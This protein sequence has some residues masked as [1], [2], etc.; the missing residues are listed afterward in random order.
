MSMATIARKSSAPAAVKGKFD[1][2][3]DV[4][5]IGSGVAGLATALFSRWHGNDVLVLEKANRLGGTTRKAAFWYWVPNNAA[6][7]AAGIKDPKKD[8]IA[9]MARLSRPEVYDPKAPKFGMPAWDYAQYEAIYDNASTATEL[10]SKKGALEYRHCDFVP[11]YWAEL[12]E[13]KAPK[14]RVLLPKGA[15]ESMSDG[16]EVAIETMSAAAKRDGVDIR[17]NHRVQRLIKNSAGEVIGVEADTPKGKKRF[18]ARKA[19]V[20]CTGGFTHNAELRKNFQAVPI[21]GGCAANS[22]EGDFVYIAGAV[23]AQ[24]RNMNY[25][26]M[27]PI[28]FEKAMARDPELIGTFSPSGD[29]MIYV[30]KEGRRVA[31]EKL[32]YNEMAQTFFQWDGAKSEYP[33]LLL[34]A[35]WDQRSQ[36]HSASDEYGRFIVPP[37]T[38]DKHVIKGATLAALS[39]AIGERLERYKK[40][41]GGLSLAP[42][43]EKTLASSI[44]RFNGFASGGRDF[45]F[46]RGERQVE[47]LFNGNVAPS[48]S[49]PNPT[50]FP[51]SDEGPYYA[52]LLTGGNL[53]TKGGPKTNVAG[54]VVDD[55]DEAIPGLYGVGNCVASASAR[56]YWAGGATIGPILAFAHLAAAAAHKERKKR[57]K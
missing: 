44:E 28:V 14:G 20:F 56:A 17:T 38:S 23:G 7:R 42:D 30:N 31:N 47:L 43:F 2:E 32:A 50:M 37:G 3:V 24:L 45:D 55:Q 41:T 16:G 1:A 21:Y 48:P 19:V 40:A 25:A 53:D 6:M 35:V 12:P 8:C 4:I 18:F 49:A 36:D 11:D 27:C 52:A 51:I 57:A 15:R 46:H 26:W 10:L 33:N 54:Q 34:I 5:A 29:S 39:E 13:D 22:N 9:Y